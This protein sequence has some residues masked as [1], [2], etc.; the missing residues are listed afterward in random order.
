MCQRCLK[1]D[2]VCDG[3]SVIVNHPAKQRESRGRGQLGVLDI[4]PRPLP[5]LVRTL[6]TEVSTHPKERQYFYFFRQHTAS[7]LSG[8]FRSNFWSILVPQL[9]HDA[10]PI[11]HAIAAVTALLKSLEKKPR[12]PLLIDAQDRHTEDYRF[13]IRQYTKAILSLKHLLST[14][15]THYTTALVASILFITI[16]TLHGDLEAA[17]TQIV[18]AFFL[19]AEALGGQKDSRKASTSQS[20]LDNDLLQMFTGLEVQSK[21]PLFYAG[22]DTFEGMPSLFTALPQPPIPN[23]PSCFESIGAAKASLDT[24]FNHIH[25]FYARRSRSLESSTTVSE[26]HLAFLR[27]WMVAFSPLTRGADTDAGSDSSKDAEDYC[28]QSILA[29]THALALIIV[30]RNGGRCSE[31]FYDSLTEHFQ[32]IIVHSRV[33]ISEMRS[34]SLPRYNFEIGVLPP[35]HVVASK[36]RIP[37]LRRD[38]IELLRLCPAQEGVWQGNLCAE[39]CEWAM[40]IEEKGVMGGSPSCRDIGKGEVIPEWNRVKLTS[41]VCWL[42]KRKSWAQCT[43]VLPVEYGSHRVLERTFTW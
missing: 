19:A 25:S 20:I 24:I 40:G 33:A 9:G 39:T 22:P 32:R 14:K 6:D 43:S 26:K 38:A 15:D 3:Y 16:E 1:S 37:G 4:K 17:S 8:Y 7:I 10:E 11:C 28:S 5:A 42:H 12:S 31:M 2:Y 18:A 41:M 13:A 27:Q 23:I 36:C 29:S 30:K 34:S 35:L 21:L